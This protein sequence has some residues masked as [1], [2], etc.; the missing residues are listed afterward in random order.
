V[1][2]IEGPRI[3]VITGRAD[4]RIHLD[5]LAVAQ[6]GKGLAFTGEKRDLGASV[7]FELQDETLALAGNGGRLHYAAAQDDDLAAMDIEF[8]RRTGRVQ[9]GDESARGEQTQTGA[10]GG[11]PAR[12]AS[13]PHPQGENAEDQEG[14]HGPQQFG[15]GEWY[16]TRNQDPRSDGSQGPEKR[17]LHGKPDCNRWQVESYECGMGDA[18]APARLCVR[19]QARHLYSALQETHGALNV[20]EAA[21]GDNGKAGR[22]KATIRPARPVLLSP[23]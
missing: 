2:V 12:P 11:E 7:R 18:G 4:A 13:T 1:G 17:I 8:G 14:A 6:H 15:F 22:L 9:Q 23:P 21:G 20:A 3:A 10:R 16:E 5:V 19:L